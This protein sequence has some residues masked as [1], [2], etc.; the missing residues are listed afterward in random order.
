MTC[1]LPVE[2]SDGVVKMTRTC[3][4]GPV[5]DGNKVTWS[6]SREVPDGVWGK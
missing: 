6:K 5:M 4:E 1:V 3:I 2:D